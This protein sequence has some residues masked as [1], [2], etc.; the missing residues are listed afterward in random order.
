MENGW[1]CTE[2]FMAW[3]LLSVS[4]C[5]TC[6]FVCNAINTNKN[7]CNTLSPQASHTV[8]RFHLSVCA[9]RKYESSFCVLNYG[10]SEMQVFPKFYCN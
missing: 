3:L 5:S 6:V 4:E 8:D 1:I 2:A 10:V 7:K 9:T